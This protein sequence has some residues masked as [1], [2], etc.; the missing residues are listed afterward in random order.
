MVVR[1]PNRARQL[2]VPPRGAER[3]FTL[4]ELMVVVIII[5][6]LAVLAIPTISGQMRSRRAQFVA[7]EVSNLY[8][9]GRLRAMGR[10]SAVMV[11]YS[12]AVDAEGRFDVREAVRT[13]PNNPACDRLPVSSCTVTNWDPNQT[14]SQVIGGV[15]IKGRAE[16]DGV[17]ARA[18]D[19]NGADVATMDVCFTPM[20][21]A[22]VRY[23]VAGQFNPLT[24]VPRLMVTRVDTS[25]NVPV[26]PARW[27]L[28][29]PN[30]SARLGTATVEATL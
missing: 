20:G 26:G 28:V 3:G 30:G 15:L 19:P 12:R 18:R 6:A 9:N 8:R 4:I 10:G 22:F 16:L 17:R 24:A 13:N 7:K 21:R 23:A 14:Q 29:L 1:V 2:A 25:T 5:G 27:V 11:R